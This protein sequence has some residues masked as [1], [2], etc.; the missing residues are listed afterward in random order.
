MRIVAVTKGFDETAP[1]AA[2]AVGLRDV[3]E[4]Y[5]DEL[6]AKAGSAH[7]PEVVWHMLGAIQRRKIKSLARVVGCWQTVSRTEEVATP[8]PPR[9]RGPGVRPGRHDRA[10]WP[11]RVRAGRGAGTGRRC[12]RPGLTVRGLMTV[13]PPG[14]PPAAAA[15]FELVAQLAAELGLAGALDGDV[16]RLEVARCG[17]LDHAA[18]GEG[19]VRARS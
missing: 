8:R 16:R 19:F 12:P 10:A 17:G 4:N 2:F 5:P 7:A 1:A 9:P 18:C 13:G 6:L 15:G 11:K 14:G 3:G